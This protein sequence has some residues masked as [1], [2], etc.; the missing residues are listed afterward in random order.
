MKEL[1]KQN[2]VVVCR[3]PSVVSTMPSSSFGSSESVRRTD[4]S[5]RAD[6]CE[7]ATAVARLLLDRLG[8]SLPVPVSRFEA[9]KKAR[10]SFWIVLVS[11]IAVSK[12]VGLFDQPAD[13]AS[14]GEK[15]RSRVAFVLAVVGALVL[16][17]ATREMQANYYYRVDMWKKNKQHV[18]NLEWIQRYVL[19]FRKPFLTM[20]PLMLTTG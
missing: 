17:V 12:Y 14:V 5:A 1:T 11:S 8:E 16:A 4:V 3:L 9:K 10:L 19:A 13:S 7:C 18:T 15:R 6:P 20:T 2:E